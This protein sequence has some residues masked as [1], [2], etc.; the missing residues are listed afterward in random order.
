MNPQ[1]INFQCP[2][3][4]EEI[5]TNFCCLRQCQKPLCPDC[6]DH[7]N[8]NHRSKNEFPEIDTLTRVK[9]MCKNKLNFVI[10]NLEEEKK[11]LEKAINIDLSDFLKK[12]IL[13]IDLIKKKFEKKIE[14][15]FFNL[16]KTFS[17]EFEKKIKKNSDFE[18]LKKKINEVIFELRTIDKNL[19]NKK[20]FENI[21]N[22]SNLD[23]EEL[24]ATFSKEIDLILSK[25]VNLPFYFNFDE[26]CLIN[27]EGFLNGFFEVKEKN[28][29]YVVNKENLIGRKILGGKDLEVMREY[30]R[31]KFVGN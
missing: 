24:L 27:L 17:F 12:S 5:Y 8:K 26:N 3:H 19:E 23:S 28:V 16:K 10:K 1:K 13:E 7:H 2:S 22:T 6:I 21:K 31:K 25:S 30:F 14:D 29:D 4:P 20:M 11:R 18:N 9:K 15:Y